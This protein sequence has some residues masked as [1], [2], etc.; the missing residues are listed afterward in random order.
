MS[1]AER[2]RRYRA[3]KRGASDAPPPRRPGRKP[4][5]KPRP[6]GPGH[7]GWPVTAAELDAYI[8]RGLH[9][10]LDRAGSHAGRI[11]PDEAWA[12]LGDDEAPPGWDETVGF[13]AWMVTRYEGRERRQA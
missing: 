10:L 4:S 6:A 8:L 9:D 12:G 13:L 1:A 2:M 5:G 7:P 11:W 3:R